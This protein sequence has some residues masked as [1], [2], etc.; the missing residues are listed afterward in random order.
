M[1]DSLALDWFAT[2]SRAIDALE[3]Q[4]TRAIESKRRLRSKGG[5]ASAPSTQEEDEALL[6][7]SIREATAIPSRKEVLEVLRSL[8]VSSPTTSTASSSDLSRITLAVYA[9]ALDDLFHEADRLQ[10][11]TW[12]WSNIEESTWSALSY[13]V[14]TLPSRLVLLARESYRILCETTSSASSGPPRINRQT[15]AATVAQLRKTP[16]VVVGALWPHSVDASSAD[17]D[18]VT[19]SSGPGSSRGSKAL[20]G[21]LLLLR[22]A[23]RLSPLSLTVHE[24]ASKRALLDE[25]R[26]AVAQQL[27]ALTLTALALP[28]ANGKEPKSEAAAQEECEKLISKLQETLQLS[29]QDED[30]L[31]RSPRLQAQKTPQQA[32]LQTLL[33]VAAADGRPQHQRS[34]TS[35]APL[36][37]SPPSRL[38][39]IWPR[40]VLYPT[41]LLI[42]LRLASQ[43]RDALS[44]AL[45]DGRETL[46]GFVRNWLIQP[47]SELLDTIRGGDAA[48]D[49]TTSIVTK[50]GRK[51]DLESLERMV[52]QYALDKGHLS[53]EDMARRESLRAKVR[54]GDL[55]VVMLA[56]E[57][58][59]KTP[60]KS[61]AGGS[62]P[63]LLLIQVQKA[64]YDL[65]VAMGGID[66][67]L[68]SQALLFGAVG[69][70]PAMGIVWAGVKAGQWLLRGRTSAGAQRGN[71]AR[72]KQRAWASMRCVDRMLTAGAKAGEEGESAAAAA[73]EYGNALL[74]LAALRKAGSS[75][76]V[77]PRRSSR[78]G[79]AG[80]RKRRVRSSSLSSSSPPPQQASPTNGA[81]LRLSAFLEDV[82]EL[83]SAAAVRA[84]KQSQ[85]NG[86]SLD[87]QAD[88][89]AREAVSRMWRCWGSTLFV[90]AL[91]E[92]GN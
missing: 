59:L 6:P 70:A 62:L 64:K 47:V 57:D 10:D 32:S 27:G 88:A 90:P 84:T 29:S 44:Q 74:E 2:T 55:D 82:R 28:S 50:E 38:S 92:K 37:L 53:P 15:V 43:N 61:L 76:L 13:L 72:E 48:G 8:S 56:Y 79:G 9:L 67:L 36:G 65:A 75:V 18:A 11:A 7:E 87:A 35:A 25:R 16:D 77:G 1:A 73:K 14:Q 39:L 12:Y 46:E 31:R 20:A 54:E 42:T 45:G 34:A 40:L 68:K 49:E 86:N 63:R 51:A 41:L 78:H 69:I 85:S 3:A 66:H 52:T 83:E 4:Q 71:T 80:H 58:Q 24:A 60:L 81:E 91:G 33:D 5:Q 21:P 19:A 26:D 89:A 17:S 22:R 23:K 30:R